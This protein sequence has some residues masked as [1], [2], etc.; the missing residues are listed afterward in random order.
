MFIKLGHYISPF[1]TSIPE[2]KP[3]FQSGAS[4]CLKSGNVSGN[5]CDIP[6]YSGN[7]ILQIIERLLH[8][9]SRRKRHE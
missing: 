5:F 3:K 8:M 6:H 2:N 4:K 9:D 7:W 1:F